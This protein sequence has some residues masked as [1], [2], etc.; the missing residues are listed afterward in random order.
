MFV[1]VALKYQTNLIVTVFMCIATTLILCER[2]LE[3]IIATGVSIQRLNSRLL[4]EKY[5][6][7]NIYYLYQQMHVYTH[8]IKSYYKSSTFFGA[9]APSSGSLYI[10]LAKVIVIKGG[11]AVA[12]LVETLRYKSEGRGFDSRWCHWNFSL[13]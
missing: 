4:K 8:C 3:L 7:I 13:T 1:T 12:Q 6:K 9:S 11:T 2:V 5:F 10:V